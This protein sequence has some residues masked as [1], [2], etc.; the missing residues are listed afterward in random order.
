M[1][2]ISWVAEYSIPLLLNAFSVVNKYTHSERGFMQ[3]YTPVH[4]LSD[5]LPEEPRAGN[6]VIDP[7]FN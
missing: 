1:T 2:A 4:R 3:R 7:E 6:S 5:K